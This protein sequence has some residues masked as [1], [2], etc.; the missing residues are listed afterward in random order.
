MQIH[1][2]NTGSSAL[3]VVYVLLQVAFMRV[4]RQIQSNF[5]GKMCSNSFRVCFIQYQLDLLSFV[6]PFMQIVPRA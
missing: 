4:E 1:L 3:C 5:G 2:K 6:V